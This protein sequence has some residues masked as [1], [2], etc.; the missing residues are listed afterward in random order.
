MVNMFQSKATH[1]MVVMEG[2]K[3]EGEKRGEKGRDSSSHTLKDRLQ[4]GS[5]L[6]TK[7]LQGEVSD[8][9]YNCN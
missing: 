2:E 1:L 9:V 8:Q 6:Q 5:D 7:E 3:R 4:L